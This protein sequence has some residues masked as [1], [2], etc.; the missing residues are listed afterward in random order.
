MATGSGTPAIQA[1]SSALAVAIAQHVGGT[2]NQSSSVS[3]V[4]PQTVPAAQPLMSGSS[5]S[6][7][8]EPSRYYY[9]R[10][11]RDK[12]FTGRLVIG[13]TNVL[14]CQSTG[15]SLDGGGTA[16]SSHDH[17]CLCGS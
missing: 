15:E 11:G 7:G 17:D 4:S 1:L 12:R 14:S 8:T 9:S 5:G 13:P 3:L 6:S 10:L 16:P 2:N